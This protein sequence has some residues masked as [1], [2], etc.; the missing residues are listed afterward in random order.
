MASDEDSV[1]IVAVDVEVTDLASADVSIVVVVIVVGV[2]ANVVVVGVV[3]VDDDNVGA[4]ADDGV[5]VDVDVVVDASA[6]VLVAIK[7]PP[8]HPNRHHPNSNFPDDAPP[9]PSPSRVAA[10]RSPRYP[11]SG[12]TCYSSFR[13]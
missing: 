9:P 7:L 5:I 10:P 2:V 8:A 3:G 1:V 12:N 6:H 4:H 13:S 11:R